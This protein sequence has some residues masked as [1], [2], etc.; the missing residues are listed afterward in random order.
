MTLTLDLACYVI[1]NYF[2]LLVKWGTEAAASTTNVDGSIDGELEADDTLPLWGEDLEGVDENEEKASSLN[3]LLDNK[4][5]NYRLLI[6]SSSLVIAERRMERIKRLLATTISMRQTVAMINWCPQHREALNESNLLKELLSKTKAAVLFHES[7][8]RVISADVVALTKDHLKTVFLFLAALIPRQA[9][10]SVPQSCIAAYTA[11]DWVELRRNYAVKLDLKGAD[12]RIVKGASNSQ[13]GIKFLKVW[14]FEPSMDK[15]LKF[16]MTTPPSSVIQQ[17]NSGVGSSP[18][19]RKR[20]VT[21]SQDGRPS[22]SGRRD[23]RDF[24]AGNRSNDSFNTDNSRYGNDRNE[25]WNT[26]TKDRKSF[27]GHFI[28]LDREAGMFYQAFEKHFQAFLSQSFRIEMKDSDATMSE[29]PQTV[30][31]I[32]NSGK[33]TISRSPATG[34]LV[35]SLI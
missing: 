33:N 27:N 23:S 31:A 14:G 15:A 2:K 4:A 12:K 11:P 5:K 8:D 1:A 16:I 17:Q 35:L 29:M 24:D 7:E 9:V 25:E 30:H 26:S 22:L 34:E 32:D 10:W 13:K 28:F 21:E 6:N 18:P 3:V 19:N 20:I